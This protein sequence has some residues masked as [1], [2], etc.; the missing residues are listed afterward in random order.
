MTVLPKQKSRTHIWTYWLPVILYA[1]LIVFLSSLSSPGVNF[2]TIFPGFDDKIIHAIEYA[3]LAIL[4]YRALLHTTTTEWRFYAPFLAIMSSVM[5]GITD[6]IHQA[7]V[8]LRQADAWD[9]LA[10]GIGASIGVGMWKW[11]F[12]LSSPEPLT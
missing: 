7:F 10:D 3:I 1:S 4:C 11:L 6:E 5:F 2:I 9:V 12:H 8:P